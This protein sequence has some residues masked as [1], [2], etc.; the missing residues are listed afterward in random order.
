LIKDLPHW[1][2]G[3][4]AFKKNSAS[5]DFFNKW[6]DFFEND[7]LL[8]DQVSLVKAL[9]ISNVR[10][11]PLSTE[12]NYHPGFRFFLGSFSNSIKIVHYLDRISPNLRKSILTI[13]QN[14]S[15]ISYHEVSSEIQKRIDAFRKKTPS[16][17]VIVYKL[18]WSFYGW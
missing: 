8:I 18:L 11:C 14:V 7:N 3:V 2:G 13:S 1:N 4:V 12:W 5:E 16:Y 15:E 10:L 17:Q 9:F 6:Q